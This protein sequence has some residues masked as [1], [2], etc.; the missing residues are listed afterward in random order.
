MG[1]NTN[2]Q[3]N[4][5]AKINKTESCWLWIGAKDTKG[6]G[7]LTSNYKTLRAH[8]YS[9]LLH[10]GPIPEGLHVCH[11][12]DTPACVNPDHLWLGTNKENHKDKIEK[13]R[14]PT[15]PNHWNQK[16]RLNRELLQALDDK[17]SNDQPTH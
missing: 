5:E 3:K 6:Y 10:R 14:I 4:F 15:G 13:G 8:R 11:S 1:R 12:C 17:V 9:Y 2:T 16:R 7:A